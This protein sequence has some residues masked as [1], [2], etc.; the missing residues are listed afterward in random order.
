[1]RKFIFLFLTF[2]YLSANCQERKTGIINDPDGYT[3]IR[4]GKGTSFEVIDKLNTDELFTY[5][6]S[7]NQ[8]WLKILITKC[9][10]DTP[11]RL[12]NQIEGYVHRSRIQDV[13]QLT[14]TKRKTLFSDIFNTEL[15]LYNTVINSIDRKSKE[16]QQLNGK[17]KVFHDYQFDCSLRSFTTYVCE[18]KDSELTQ[19]YMKLMVTQEE[20]ADEAP[21]YALGRLFICEPEWTFEQITSHMMLMDKLEWGL[22]NVIYRMPKE[23]A[24]HHK[25]KYNELRTAI[26][27]S[28]VDFSLYE[29]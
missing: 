3:N 26:G 24:V 1:M 18:H 21:T 2:F 10:C 16:Y 29:E 7:T 20:S 15:E 9:N 22:V 8:S 28:K 23:E 19:Q 27:M 6:D 13:D 5:I 14:P 4:L 25:R 17:R 12:Y 11:H